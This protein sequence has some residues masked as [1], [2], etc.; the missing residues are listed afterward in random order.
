[1]A[2]SLECTPQHE[3]LF[4][5]FLH[6]SPH[7]GQIVEAQTAQEVSAHD[8]NPLI[9]SFHEISSHIVHF[10]QRPPPEGID[11]ELCRVI[12]R[13]DGGDMVQFPLHFG[14]HL[15]DAAN[16]GDDVGLPVQLKVL[17]NALRTQQLHALQTEMTQNLVRM[18]LAI[19]SSESGRV[20]PD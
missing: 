15:L 8:G 6:L 5:Q 2:A 4:C 18:R 9:D 11:I 17:S 16:L 19:G 12:L 10:F 7:P 14:A 3:D 20:L 1:M 13:H